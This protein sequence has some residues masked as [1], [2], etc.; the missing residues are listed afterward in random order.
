MVEPHQQLARRLAHKDRK[1]QRKFDACIVVAL[2][3]RMGLSMMAKLETTVFIVDGAPLVVR[4]LVEL[5]E[6]AGHARVVGSSDNAREALTEILHRSPSV[7]LL[8]LHLRAG[9]GID[10]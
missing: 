9:S 8:D 10:L 5:I 2:L 3:K 7:V 1:E 6:S 4:H